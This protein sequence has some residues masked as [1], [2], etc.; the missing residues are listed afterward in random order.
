M[1]PTLLKVALLFLSVSVATICCSSV[2]AQSP[3][4]E[5]SICKAGVRAA[6]FG[7]W[8]WR[9]ASQV[10]VF[11]LST[12]FKIEEIPY[13]LAP[14]ES[15]NAVA[16]EST[17]QVRFVYDGTV[18]APQS[19]KNC[20]TIKRGKVRDKKNGHVAELVAYS[21]DGDQII[22]HAIIVIDPVVTELQALSNSLAHELGHNF[23]LKDCYSCKDR[24]TVMN[25]IN[26]RKGLKAPTACDVAQVKRAYE[27]LRTH[28]RASPKLAKIPIDDGEEPV[29][30]DTPIVIPPLN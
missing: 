4:S 6:A 20:L 9:P 5:V 1:K 26:D 16:E 25:V 24:S 23:G 27:E 30:D 11:V 7:S 17:S 22:T 28:E 29:E 19:C 14:V 8:M 21:I 18:S 10:K 2:S 15:W 3:G 13:L 12:D